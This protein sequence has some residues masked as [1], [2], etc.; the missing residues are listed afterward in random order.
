MQKA[1]I[2]TGG[3]LVINSRNDLNHST[4]KQP[5]ERYHWIN[6]FLTGSFVKSIVHISY[7]TYEL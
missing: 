2:Q 6:V 7:L 1:K 4:C 5:I 3:F